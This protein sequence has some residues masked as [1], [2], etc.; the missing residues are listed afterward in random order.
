VS[1][2]PVCAFGAAT[3]RHEEDSLTLANTVLRRPFQ[4]LKGTA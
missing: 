1:D 3:P 4:E 2:H